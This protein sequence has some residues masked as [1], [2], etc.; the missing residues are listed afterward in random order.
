MLIDEGR[1]RSLL[2]NVREPR[3]KCDC[4]AT[5]IVRK[6]NEGTGVIEYRARN[7]L[8]FARKGKLTCYSH[9]HL[10]MEARAMKLHKKVIDLD[11]RRVG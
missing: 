11:S 10:E 5:V 7:C 2:P 8:R 6:T 9:D 3:I 1:N 4:W